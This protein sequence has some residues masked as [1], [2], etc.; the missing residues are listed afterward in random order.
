M[1]PDPHIFDPTRFL[2]K[3]GDLDNSASKFW[4]FS[5]GAGRRICPGRH[6]ALDTMWIA[7]ASMLATF[8]ME[9]PLDP[10]GN[11][12]EPQENYSVGTI[13]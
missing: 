7:V 4:E 9:K 5:F 13:W 12:I 2:T 11:V 10:C 3:D 6:F 1:F 8:T